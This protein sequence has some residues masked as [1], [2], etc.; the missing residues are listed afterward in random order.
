MYIGMWLQFGLV[1]G[2]KVAD[3]YE[4]VHPSPA[5]TA[6]ISEPVD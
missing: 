3:E 4:Q 6:E 5:P 1:D 2:K